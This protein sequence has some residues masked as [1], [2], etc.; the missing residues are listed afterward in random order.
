MGRCTRP[1]LLAA[2]CAAALLVLRAAPLRAAVILD[3]LIIRVY[4]NA[5]VLATD[6]ARALKRAGDVLARADI[7]VEWIECGVRGKG[8]LGSACEAPPATGELVV[9]LIAGPRGTDHERRPLGYSLVDTATGTGTLATVFADR[10]DWLAARAKR[11]RTEVLGRAIAHE[12]G[13]L[14]LG[15]NDHSPAGLMRAVWTID[16]LARN[17]QRDWQFSA[18]QRTHLRNAR[19]L[20]GSARRNAATQPARPAAGG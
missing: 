14:M 7:N 9:R 3:S 12:V 16:E 18:D 15:S 13:H 4:D 8:R 10:V 11:D 5:G 2:G 17:R 6:R 1:L 19:V 20:G